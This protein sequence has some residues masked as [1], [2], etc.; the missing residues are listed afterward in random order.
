MMNQ[1]GARSYVVACRSGS[2]IGKV[3][4]HAMWMLSGCESSQMCD[5]GW[6]G[7]SSVQKVGEKAKKRYHLTRARGNNQ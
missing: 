5:S 3:T 7:I 6:M 2:L 4:D 1:S